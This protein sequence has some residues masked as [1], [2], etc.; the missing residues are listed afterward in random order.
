MNASALCVCVSCVGTV[1]CPAAGL[2]LDTGARLAG[3]HMPGARLWS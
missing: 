2:K 1:Q 3:Q